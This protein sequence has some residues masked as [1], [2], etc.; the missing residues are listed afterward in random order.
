MTPLYA[1]SGPFRT[2][3]VPLP[4]RLVTRILRLAGFGT[5]SDKAGRSSAPGHGKEAGRPAAAPAGKGLAANPLSGDG[6]STEAG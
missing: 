2:A 6:A 1:G 5:G 3:S 4:Y